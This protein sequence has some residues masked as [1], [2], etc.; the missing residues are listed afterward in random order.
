MSD[1]FDQKHSVVRKNT[2]PIMLHTCV[3]MFIGTPNRRGADWWDAGLQLR[4]FLVLYLCKEIWVW[5][6]ALKSCTECTS[7]FLGRLRM[8]LQICTVVKSKLFSCFYTWQLISLL[9]SNDS[10]SSL[11]AL[12]RAHCVSSS[13]PFSSDEHHN[14]IS[15][16]TTPLLWYQEGNEPGMK[17]Y[18]SGVLCQRKKELAKPSG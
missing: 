6:H 13:A 8:S 17:E 7:T 16:P 14:E 15:W 4:I 3:A 9:S 1:V 12:N 11:S 5:I 10:D 18:T 2:L